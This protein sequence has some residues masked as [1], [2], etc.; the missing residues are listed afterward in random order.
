MAKQ[1]TYRKQISV[2]MSLRLAKRNKRGFCPVR[3]TARWHGEELQM[4]TG[5]LVMPTGK[6]RRG[7]EESFWDAEAGQ[8]VGDHPDKAYLNSRLAEWV[9]DVTQA[10]ESVFDRAPFEKVSKEQ[11][12]AELFPPEVEEVPEPA[13]V[14]KPISR[15]FRQVLEEWKEENR[16]LGKDS[17]RKYDQLATMMETWR[18][19][20]RPEQV[21]QK[22]AKEY[23]QHLLD[24][25]KS[26]ATIKVHFTGLR[27]CLEQ[28]GL[29]ADMAWLQYSA[30][31][32]PQLDLEIEEVQRL[33][34]WR[35]TSDVLA[36]ERDRWLFQLFSGRRY[37]DLEKFDPRER[38][39]LTLED[40]RKVPALLHAQGKTGNDAAVPLPPIAV[41]IGERWGWQFPARTWQQR[42]DYIKDI[43]QQAGLNREWD[44][45]LITGGKVVHNWRPIWQVISTHT[46][47]HTAATLLKQVS[48]G[49]KAL[50]KLVLGHAE[51]D[52]TDRYAKDKARLLAPAVLDAWQKIL[53][54]WYDRV[55]A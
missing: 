17:L 2:R 15:T 23:Q 20:L 45:R 14:V 50:A 30:K 29:P 3:M 46:A 18:P 54:D 51:E 52:V 49:N 7:K 12:R 22:I 53:G 28:L 4:D 10:F 38:I 6:N 37:E 43:A 55:P 24:L 16:N 33:I 27:K 9:R 26:D 48:N 42:G 40:G 5:E 19:D 1:I 39:T 44:D 21:T 47:R 34:R 32:A 25:Q 8:V 31:N 13:E 11:L 36:E 35:P 41:N